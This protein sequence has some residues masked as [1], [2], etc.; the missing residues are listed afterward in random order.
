[1]T[2]KFIFIHKIFYI[3]VVQQSNLWNIIIQ[4]DTNKILPI[5]GEIYLKEKI[6]QSKGDSD[7]E[8]PLTAVILLTL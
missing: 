7:L 5:C 6:Q 4:I 8:T 3:S 1:M 2:V